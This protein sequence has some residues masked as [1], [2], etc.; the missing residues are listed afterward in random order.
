MTRAPVCERIRDRL[1]DRLDQALAPGDAAEV[2]GHLRQ[3]LG[4][5]G[6]M[7]ALRALVEQARALPRERPLAADLWPGVVARLQ[8]RR[9]L[10]LRAG[11]FAAA[12]AVA[13]LL[14]ALGAG[15]GRPLDDGAEGRGGG[16][17]P[18]L[19]EVASG[20]MGGGG[21]GGAGGLAPGSGGGAGAPRPRSLR[22][23]GR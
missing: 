9:Q 17:L 12:A 14:G 16:M 21:M 10:R 5:Q 13:L 4:C 18:S 1:D 15:R 2:D 6:E 3:C 7:R 20:G 8:Q 23:P 19:A 11:S 22:A